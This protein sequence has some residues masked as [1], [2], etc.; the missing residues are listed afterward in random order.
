M[1]GKKSKSGRKPSGNSVRLVAGFRIDPETEKRLEA[2]CDAQVVRPPATA[3]ML[4]ALKQ[5]LTAQGF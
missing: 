5:F 1:A 3:L 4:V 2:F